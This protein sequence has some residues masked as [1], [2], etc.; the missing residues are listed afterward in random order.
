[1]QPKVSIIMPTYKG[2]N[3][4]ASSI[5]SVLNQSYKNIELIVIDDNGLGTEEQLSTEIVCNKYIIDS[6]FVYLTHKSNK[7]GSA[8]RNTGIKQASGKYI[9]FLDD[10]DLF[11]SDKI[12]KQ[13][14]L[15]ETL[16]N[17]YGL[18]YGGL[19]E[20][21][22]EA[23]TKKIMPQDT[24][25]FLY[26][27]LCGKLYVCSST[28]IIRRDVIEKVGYWD[29]S[30]K[31]HQD[32][33]YIVRIGAEFKVAY[34][35]SVCITK[36]RVDR[37]LPQEGE[38]CKEFRLHYLRKM[39]PF[40]QEYSYKEQK[41]IYFVNYLAIAKSYLKNKKIMLP[42]YYAMK[43]KKPIKMCWIYIKDTINYLKK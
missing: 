12:Q 15:F 22:S 42:L 37:N 1:M 13:V 3:Y 32:M 36:V 30:F 18:V 38:K 24:Q 25:D 20:K 7:N 10:D 23:K 19:I 14:E 11:I 28:I 34:V 33:E 5:E 41:E 39:I 26:D 9:A 21:Y 35:D 29:E 8:A 16:S 40:I 27:Y 31:R 4:I 2:A 6:R 17:D 43:S